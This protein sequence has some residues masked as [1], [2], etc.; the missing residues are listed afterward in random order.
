MTATNT[1]AN[2]T[3]TTD[4][5]TP[6]VDVDV[7]SS[8]TN[9]ETEAPAKD[10]ATPDPAPSKAVAKATREL[11]TVRFAQQRELTGSYSD[12]G[13]FYHGHSPVANSIG[14]E[15]GV[16]TKDE[17]AGTVQRTGFGFYLRSDH[18]ADS[19]LDCSDY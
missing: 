17:Q 11:E 15:L 10:E 3:K 6:V 14:L 13:C 16:V 1:K 8:D 18:L 4:D 12:F 9:P 19:T 2:D 5:Q 7:V